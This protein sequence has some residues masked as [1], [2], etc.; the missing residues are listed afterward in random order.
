MPDKIDFKIDGRKINIKRH[1]I[2]AY[3]NAT[4]NTVT[5]ALLK[6]ILIECRLASIIEDLSA[7]KLA[8]ILENELCLDIYLPGVKINVY[9]NTRTITIPRR[10]AMLFATHE[11]LSPDLIEKYLKE[12]TGKTE[13][14]LK[15]LNDKDL[16]EIVIEVMTIRETRDLIGGFNAM[17]NKCEG[18]L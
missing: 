10:Q 2:N 11:D 15:S 4:G 6:E 13:D 7:R 9:D 1:I 17:Q 18:L 14:E 8:Q 3:R 12:Y 16:S 5:D